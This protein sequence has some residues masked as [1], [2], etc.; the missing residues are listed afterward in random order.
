MT[1]NTATSVTI[2]IGD[3]ES[4]SGLWQSPPGAH[5]CLI[6]AHGAGAG[7]TH[8]GMAALADGLA[9]RG[10]ATLRYQFPY[11]ERGSKRPDSPAVAHAA[12]RAAV[13]EAAR[14]A[15]ELPLFAGGR[16]FG[17]RMTSQ[18]QALEP[19]PGVKGLVFFAFP[20]HPA[21]KPSDE[22]AK[23]LFDITI[24][25]LFTQGT[26]DALAELDLLR[27]VVGML[28]ARATL[29]LLDDADHSFHVPAK[30]GR[31]DSEVMAELLDA[32]VAWMGTVATRS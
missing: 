16:S 26:R 31:K 28:G 21:G 30:T 11:M 3:S 14:R 1:E 8:K 19:L 20:L 25:M 10:V 17:G 13:A 12:V 15:P 24:P 27:P 9:A 18:A 4:V 5:A 32:A 22:R 29:K 6:L 7:M 23:H 2:P